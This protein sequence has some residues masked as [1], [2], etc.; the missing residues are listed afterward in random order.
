MGRPKLLLPWKQTTVIGQI[1]S[2]WR[3]LG[4]GQIALVMRQNDRALAAELE[5]L[6]FPV[7]NRIANPEPEHGM[8]S[9]ILC[10]ARWNGWRPEISSWAMVLADQPHLR[11]ETLR[12]LLEFAARHPDAICQPEFGGHGGHPVLL[13]PS[14]FADLKRTGAKKMKDFLNQTACQSVK[15]SMNDPGLSLDMDTPEDYIRIQSR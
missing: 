11:M 9:S 5:R 7:A 1:L 8:F 10:A 6:A 3:G 13:P 15:C 14:A 4:A 2:T 12:H